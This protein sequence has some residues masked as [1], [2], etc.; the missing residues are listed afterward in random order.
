MDTL[1]EHYPIQQAPHCFSRDMFSCC[2]YPN[3]ASAPPYM[4]GSDGPPLSLSLP[5]SLSADQARVSFCAYKEGG[6]FTRRESYLM[7][8]SLGSL[9]LS[10]WVVSARVS[11]VTVEN[12]EEP[13]RMSFSK[14]QVSQ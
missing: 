1:T 8:S 5:A 2:L 3:L 11:G 13:V 12:L 4:P 7:T 6:F 9:T 10:S 14:V